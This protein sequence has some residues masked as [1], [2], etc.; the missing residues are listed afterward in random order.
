MDKKNNLKIAAG[1]ATAL[2]LA[3]CDDQKAAEDT[4]PKGTE[5]PA[6]QEEGAAPAASPA[7]YTLETVVPGS[8]FH[9]I[10]GITETSDGKLLAG[11]VLGRAIYE[12]DKE[13][14]TVSIYEAPPTGMADDLE[15]G[16][17]GALGWTAFLDGKYYLRTKDGEL[18]TL[19]EGLPGLNST[20]WNMEGRLFATQVF[21]G[22]ALYEL[23]PQGIAPPRKIMEDM[24]GLNGFDFGPDGKLYG[25]LWFK[26][27]IVRVDVDEGTLETVATGF[28]TPAAVNFDSRGNLWAVDT[29]EGAVYKV[30]I[31]DGTR[32][33]VADV[34]A[35]IDNL[36][37]TSDD[38]LFI[39]NMADNAVI[40][41][42]TETGES[43]P[44]VKGKL[45]VAADL[46]L[47]QEDGREVLY[48]GDVFALRKV[49]LADGSV[50]EVGRVFGSNVDYPISVAE[51]HGRIAVAG[52]SAG[53]VQAFDVGAAELPGPH[54]GFNA[55]TDALPLA[56]GGLLVA[57]YGR[58][59][60]VKVAAD[61]WKNRTNFVTGLKGPANL[62]QGPDGR[63][64]LSEQLA[65]RISVLDLETGALM[66]VA[67]GLEGPEGFDIDAAGNLYVAEVGAHRIA[68]IDL[69]T[70]EKTVIAKDL[71]IGFGFEGDVLPLNVPTGV[72]V[73]K[74]GSVYFTSDMEAAL[75]K[76]T[77]Q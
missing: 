72:A 10:H 19:A 77:P 39:T 68:R 32:M 69:S 3:A 74:D 25:P 36:A 52:W 54:H 42:D 37:I 38:R 1:L 4:A 55:P 27:E 5:A 60:L 8:A 12:I 16:P 43:T 59:A 63:V 56:D 21:L 34:D 47:V 35:A 46:E 70:S 2:A 23:D 65:G 64:Y 76:L 40:E 75:Y 49:D 24:G 6:A 22:D 62:M 61:D 53:A 33:K 20:A 28:E 13:T 18:R 58:G 48:V 30:D 66:P 51:A 11:S 29:A 7:S 57:E 14:G 15:E 41:I 31:D 67:E 71:P 45:A 50:S 44:L 17:D 26:G 9:G 73:A